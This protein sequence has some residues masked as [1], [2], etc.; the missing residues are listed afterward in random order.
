M[1]LLCIAYSMLLVSTSLRSDSRTHLFSRFGS[2]VP[3][4]TWCEA[5]EDAALEALAGKSK[6]FVNMYLS[7]S[8][9][10][11]KICFSKWTCGYNEM[12]KVF[13]TNSQPIEF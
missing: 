8:T 3:E 5:G 12:H 4:V 2:E 6:G 10:E 13:R 7:A 9:F 11:C 1:C